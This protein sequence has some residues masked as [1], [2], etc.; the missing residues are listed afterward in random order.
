MTI[1][2]ETDY[3]LNLPCRIGFLADFHNAR[4]EPI[5]RSLKTRTP[6]I[7][8]I[9]GDLFR[10]DNMN[11]I[12]YQPNVVTLLDACIKIAPT[13]LSIGN[14]EWMLTPD[15]LEFIGSR[16]VCVLDD[17]WVTIPSP[18]ATSGTSSAAGTSGAANENLVIGGFTSELTQ[19]SRICRARGET[20]RYL[21]LTDKINAWL[22][23]F[24]AQKGLKVLLCHHPEY[25]PKYLENRKIDLVLSG[26]AH[27]GQWRIAGRGLFAPGQGLF[28]KLTGGIHDSL[29]ISRG[30]SNTGNI[31]PRINNPAEIIYLR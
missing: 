31:V 6:D 10:G 11:P 27:G 19:S 12:P 30:L 18:G 25:Y 2:Q 28:P 26:H 4:P 1:L 7:I 13:Y 21:D 29:V 3:N 20:F 9:A 23:E 16:G 5:I 15:E 17:R 22:D 8:C 14:H 24:E